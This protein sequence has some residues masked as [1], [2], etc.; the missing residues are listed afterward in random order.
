[1]S[2]SALKNKPASGHE[3]ISDGKTVWINA[4]DGCCLGRYVHSRLIVHM[5]V[6]RDTDGQ[7]ESGTACMNCAEGSTWEGFKSAMLKH[8]GIMVPDDHK[9]VLAPV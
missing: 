3:T 1:M 7:I 6:H 2:A 4:K 9:P 8:H 5:D